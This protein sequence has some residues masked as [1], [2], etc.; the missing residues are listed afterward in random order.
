MGHRTQAEAL[1]LIRL[2]ASQSARMPLKHRSNVHNH[3]DTHPLGASSLRDSHIP[4]AATKLWKVETET[5]FPLS[6][7]Q[8]SLLG[9]NSERRPGGGASL[10][11]HAHRSIRN[12]CR[13]TFR[14]GGSQVTGPIRPLVSARIHSLLK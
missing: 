8:Y 1:S 11:L 6:T 12:C 2:S 3:N 10:L 13:P 4:T 9:A 7:A 14:I 5:G